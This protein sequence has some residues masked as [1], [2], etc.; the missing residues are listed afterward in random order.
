[1]DLLSDFHRAARN[2]ADYLRGLKAQGRT[3]IGYMCTY[4][5]EEIITAAGLHPTRI[6]SGKA[7]IHLADAHLQAYC[8]S[9]VRGVLEEALS[10]RLD[11]L[12]GMVFP[13]TC[14]SIQRLSDIWRLNTDFGFFAD[15]I[16]PVKL[17]TD[18]SGEYMKEVLARF[19]RD[20]AAWLG[21][22]IT[23]QALRETVSKY[24]RLRSC[25][26]E[27]YQLR[28]DNP[29]LVRGRDVWAIIKGAM[30][31]P[32]DELLA[33]LP[34]VIA[35]IKA[36]HLAWDAGRRKRLLVIGGICD[37]PDVYDLI[38]AAGGVAVWDDLCTGSRYFEGPISEEGDPITA[39]A[40]RYYS[41]PICPAK[42]VSLTARG[43]N[44]VGLAREHGAQGAFFP[45]LKFCDPHS[46]DY[47]YLKDFLGRIGVPSLLYEIEDQLPS[48]G[49]LATRLETFIEMP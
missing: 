49:Q 8:C 47:P 7:E 39:L 9:L 16:L 26:R 22:E 20:L 2:S 23:D 1:M 33:R 40:A 25:L 15:V 31:M 46:F 10:G 12:S 43:A 41:R 45:L 17:N 14:D 29:G 42:H 11:Y 13:H 21:R 32:R 19:R 35:S 4:A 37:H 28:A 24:N 44:A 36:G 3:V 27:I 6:F 5:P 38:E 34:E 18:S 48:A 30:I